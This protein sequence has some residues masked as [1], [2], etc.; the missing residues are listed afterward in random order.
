[1]HELDVVYVTDG[2]FEGGVS[3]AVVSELDAI[4]GAKT[5]LRVGL[6]LV[7]AELLHLPWPVHP[8]IR[9]HIDSGRLQLVRPGEN[10]QAQMALVHHPVLFQNLPRSALPVTAERA[11]LILHHPMFDNDG[12]RQY[13]LGQVQQNIAATLAPEVYVAPVSPAVRRTL[14]GHRQ[15]IGPVVEEDWINLLSVSDWPFDPDRTPPDPAH[16]VV[17]RHA[18]PHAQKWPDTWEEAASAYCV[19]WPAIE[20]RILGGGIFLTEHYGRALPP[21]WVELPFSPDGVSEFLSGL[22]F[23][24]Y[25][26]SATWL[27][28]FGRTVLEA[29]ACGL[30]TILP[31]HFEELFREAAVYAEPGDVAQVIS[32]FLDDPDAWQAQ[33]LRAR[34]WV[35]RHHSAYHHAFDRLMLYGL[36]DRTAARAP[37]EAPAVHR[38]WKAPVLFLSTNGI[39]VGHLTQQL[40]IAD[41]LPKDDLQPVF[42]SMSFSL[43]VAQEAGYPVFYLPHHKHLDADPQA[44]NRVLAEELFDLIRH[45]RPAILAYDGT[46]VFGGLTDVLRTFPDLI[47]LWVRRAMWRECHRPFLDH[48]GLFTGV[49]EPGELAGELDFGPTREVRHLVHSVGP[50]LHIDPADRHDRATARAAY[51]LQDGDMAVALQMGSGANFDTRD[52]RETIIARLMRDPRVRVLEI[53]SPLA[54]LP[55]AVTG[56][57][58]RLI[59]MREFPSFLNSRAIDAAIGVAGYNSFHEQLLGGIPT[60]FV[61]NEAPEMDSQLT[62]AQWAEVTGHGLCLRARHDIGALDHTLQ[63]ILDDE[64]RARMRAAM[65]R[66]EPATGAQELAEIVADHSAMIRTD[67]APSASYRR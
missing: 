31:P 47:S 28:A 13:D 48:A 60:V 49:L 58:E 57:G 3:T 2:R 66:L 18:R 53:V 7:R 34:R 36:R 50:V 43:R 23:Y 30:V 40:A 44:W 41:R 6:L 25:Y 12:R 61:P 51:G 54:P 20:L 56:A 22:D 32:G 33:R 37:A 14:T 42:A 15:D 46:A 55:P 45:L 67:I 62:R 10:W 5:A 63:R 16:I 26:H 8:G 35:V 21:A 9:A 64:E 27:E 1:M 39:G 65:A 17:G 11:L 29:L 52:L 19:D 4:L 38:G 24:V 59:Q